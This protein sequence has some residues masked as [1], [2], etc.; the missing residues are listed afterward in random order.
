MPGAILIV[1]SDS[2]L[3]S[4]QVNRMPCVAEDGFE[5]LNVVIL[6]RNHGW[7]CRDPCDML[8]HFDDWEWSAFLLAAG[9][10]FVLPQHLQN[11]YSGSHFT[12]H[13]N[14]THFF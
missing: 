12:L 13:T 8:W 3:M 2:F 7:L 11:V 5:S 4:L 10:E 14:L 9:V 6:T 1:N